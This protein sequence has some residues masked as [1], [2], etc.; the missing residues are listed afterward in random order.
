MSAGLVVVA[1]HVAVP[2]ATAEGT[3][4][5]SYNRGMKLCREAGGFFAATR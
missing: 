2:L 3:L 4:V 1:L 5:A